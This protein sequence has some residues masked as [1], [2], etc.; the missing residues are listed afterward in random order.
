MWGAH[1][2]GLGNQLVPHLLW[3]APWQRLVALQVSE[4]HIAGVA[5]ALAGQSMGSRLP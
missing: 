4:R 2:L 1:A 5:G 3:S